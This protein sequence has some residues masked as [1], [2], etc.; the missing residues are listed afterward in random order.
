MKF[1]TVKEG[2]QAVVYNHLGEGTLVIGPQRIY[3]FR[4]R[5]HRLERYT[6]DATQYIVM[7]DKDGVVK[8]K[9]GPCEVFFNPLI[10]DSI[11]T[12]SALKLDANHM[13]VVYKRLKDS[14]V[15]RRVIQGPVVF[16]PQAE[17]WM[18]M[19]NWHG[20][21][22]NNQG[23][24]IPAHYKFTQLTVI[25]DQ[26][27]YNV[28]DVRTNDD[29]MI[30][31]KLMLFYS[32][33]D[34]VKMLD[35]THDPIADLIN[36]VCAD[37]IAFVG[38]LSYGAFLEKSCILNDLGTYSQLI[39]RSE[40]IGFNIGKV[41]YRGYHSSEQL[42]AMQNNAIES[43][44]QM[45]LEA[46]VEDQK[47]KLSHF[48]LSKEQARLNNKHRMHEMKQKHQQETQ[49]LKQTH[50]LELEQLKHSQTLQINSQ[51]TQADLDHK[52]SANDQRLQFLTQLQ[53]L[54]VNLDQYLVSQQK[55]PI[56]E[57]IHFI[58]T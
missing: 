36:A 38:K 9:Q 42:Q 50:H 28:R 46:E 49:E 25:P 10:L 51:K 22:L 29:T 45:R 39:S 30:T 54:G 33:V 35:T 6:A 24:M 31:V 55:P 57:E 48:K 11:K 47:Q 4:K 53:S 20:S 40:R 56:R 58:K 37:V 41:V 34:V 8:H 27:Y 12:E 18:H 21:D 7:K 44:T 16:V 13:V 43:R 32:I 23:R 17:E 52:S 3:L 2:E 26:F 14:N 19:F 15:Q 5:L 1:K